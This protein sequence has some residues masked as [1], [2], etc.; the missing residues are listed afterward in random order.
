MLSQI[1]EMC[2]GRNHDPIVNPLVIYRYWQSM[3]PNCISWHISVVLISNLHS[4]NRYPDFKLP[5]NCVSGLP[6][7]IGSFIAMFE[8]QFYPNHDPRHCL[9]VVG[10]GQVED[11]HVAAEMILE[12]LKKRGNQ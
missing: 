3:P 9:R 6:Q 4:K 10:S 11:P 1:Y 2:F 5:N 12:A 8:P 7:A